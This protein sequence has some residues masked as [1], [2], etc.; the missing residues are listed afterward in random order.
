M[1]EFPNLATSLNRLDP[2]KV[3]KKEEGKEGEQG[4]AAEGHHW[5]V[6]DWPEVLGP[7]A[8]LAGPS[9]CSLPPPLLPPQL[10]CLLCP[11]SSLGGGEG[12]RER[13]GKGAPAPNGACT[14][15]DGGTTV[16][17]SGTKM[18][19][20]GQQADPLTQ[21]TAVSPSLPWPQG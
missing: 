21:E 9:M 7:L 3:E 2:N 17:N 16:A 10:L 20:L 19:P 12:F 11:H 6:T 18:C 5:R 15:P 1:D 14:I 13:E 4:R 8:M